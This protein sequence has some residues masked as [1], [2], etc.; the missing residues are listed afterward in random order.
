MLVLKKN[1]HRSHN[2][3]DLGVPA[4]KVRCK[5]ERFDDETSS[6]DKFPNL[7]NRQYSLSMVTLRRQAWIQGLI[8]REYGLH[9]LKKRLWRQTRKWE[10]KMAG[11]YYKRGLGEPD[12]WPLP[13]FQVPRLANWSSSSPVRYF[14]RALKA[15]P[16]SESESPH[17]RNFRLTLASPQ[18]W[19]K[20]W[21]GVYLGRHLNFQKLFI[22]KLTEST[23]F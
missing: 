11:V 18:N 20:C 9:V 6:A 7:I 12:E 17:P 5:V 22:P 19:L 15:N 4:F 3:Q 10:G 8:G 21:L 1:G 13:R 14:Y 2:S 23:L 16:E